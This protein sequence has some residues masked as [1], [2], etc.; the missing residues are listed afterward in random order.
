MTQ[1]AV[2]K[3]CEIEIDRDRSSQA[4]ELTNLG[5]LAPLIWI[6]KRYE[7]IDPAKKKKFHNDYSIS[8]KEMKKLFTQKEQIEL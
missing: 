8:E 2:K 5:D 3:F 4:A 7:K 6:F 1:D